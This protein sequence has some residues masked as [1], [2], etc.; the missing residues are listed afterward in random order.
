M[1]TQWIGKKLFDAPENLFGP[2]APRPP[3]PGLYLPPGAYI[4]DYRIYK[5]EDYPELLETQQRLA[6]RGLKS[7][8]LRLI[9]NLL[10]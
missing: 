6:A 4:P 7:P 9:Y 2:K 8:W 1:L 5:V 10:I 3:T